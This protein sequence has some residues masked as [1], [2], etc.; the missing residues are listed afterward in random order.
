MAGTATILSQCESV[1]A[2]HNS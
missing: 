1:H 2:M